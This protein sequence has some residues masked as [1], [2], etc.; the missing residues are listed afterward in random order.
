MSTNE[1]AMSREAARRLL[2]I[3]EARKTALNDSNRS[4][5]NKTAGP[6]RR[7]NVGM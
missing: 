2:N 3:E 5:E 4:V 6:K 1:L 7:M